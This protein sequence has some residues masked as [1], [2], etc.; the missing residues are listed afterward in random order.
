MTGDLWALAAAL[1]LATVQLTLS[2]ILTLRQLGGV[3]VAGPRDQSRE[4]T[5]V[6]GRVVRAHRN[7]LEIL[8]QF[9]GSSLCLR[10][11]WRA[12]LPLASGLGR[13]RH[14]RRGPV[15]LILP[16]LLPTSAAH[17]WS[18]PDIALMG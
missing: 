8:P 17:A 11:A 9:I 4:V 15:P 7:L 1:L 13:H 3:W 14:R 2:S 6:S 18:L 16:P 10:A 12:A 5:G